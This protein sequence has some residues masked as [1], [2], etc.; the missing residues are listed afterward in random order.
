MIDADDALGVLHTDLI[1]HGAGDGDVDD[2]LR[3]DA[4]AGLTDLLI[5]GEPAVVHERTGRGDLSAEKPGELTQGGK[6]VLTLYAA[7]AA[8][9]N[10]R[11]VYRP[12]AQR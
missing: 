12:S 3:L 10:I 6:V 11:L 7:S 8:D 9:E 1:L 5:M 2:K 4:R